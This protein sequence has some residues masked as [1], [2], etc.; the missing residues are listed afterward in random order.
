LEG[1]SNPWPAVYKDLV[2]LHHE[3]CFA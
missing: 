3:V 1:H 2:E